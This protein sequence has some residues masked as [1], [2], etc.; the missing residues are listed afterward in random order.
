MKNFFSSTFM[1]EKS[2]S[3]VGI[4]HPIKL[5][6]YKT[7]NEQKTTDEPKPKFGI[8]IV[9]KAYTGEGTKVEEEEVEGI[10]DDEK[11]VEEILRKL[12][13]NQATP[14]ILKDVMKDLM[15]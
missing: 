12:E 4:Y 6:Y 9:K 8:K 15:A 5:E 2:L 1:E 14:V 7:M 3:E 13:R 11:E 10:S